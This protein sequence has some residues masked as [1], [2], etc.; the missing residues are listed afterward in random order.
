MPLRTNQTPFATG[1][2]VGAA[3]VPSAGK[4]IAGLAHGHGLG[5]GKH[6]GRPSSQGKNVVRK[7]HPAAAARKVLAQKLPSNS[8]IGMSS[9]GKSVGVTR[10]RKNRPGTLAL[11][12]IKRYQKSTDTLLKKKPFQRLCRDIA[13]DSANSSSFPEGVRWRMDGLLAL[14]EAAE[15]YLTGLFEDSNLL[16]IHGKRVTVMQ[17]DM[18]LGRRVR[19]EDIK[20]GQPSD[21][22]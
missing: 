11:R 6:L 2:G 21:T 7:L 8:G 15:A 20:I 19:G 5:K 14:Q 4:S 12:E 17:K 10:P 1:A 22:A 18:K 13:N 9:F 16:A 3:P